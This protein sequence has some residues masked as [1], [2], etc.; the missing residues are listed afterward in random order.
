MTGP[1]LRRRAL[2]PALAAALLLLAACTATTPPAAPPGVDTDPRPSA[3]ASATPDDACAPGARL[4]G[5]TADDLQ[6]AL[7]TADPGDVLQLSAT[8]YPGRFVITR[9]GTAEDPIVLCGTP[10]TT[11]EGEGAATTGTVLRLVGADHWRL[12]DFAVRSAQR[13]V[14]LDRASHN[15]LHG[16]EVSDTGGQGIRLHNASTNNMIVDSIVRDTGVTDRDAGEGIAIGSRES[17]WCDVSDC[18]PDRSDGTIVVGTTVDHTAGEAISA[19]EGTSAGVIRDNWLSRGDGTSS[20][21]VVD[22]KGNGWVFAQNQVGDAAGPGVQV[23]SFLPDWGL[24]NRIVANTFGGAAEE[25][26]VQVIGVAALAA[27]E[28]GC[29]NAMTWGPPARANVE[30]S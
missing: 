29:D 23:H 21:A 30:C 27:T 2:A 6:D 26:A 19:E 11:L 12:E 25:L 16:L 18:E 4:V 14:V 1:A 24:D 7:D 5:E 17:S 22:L 20:D 8:T 10:G 15:E 28:V 13:G 9:S 3:S